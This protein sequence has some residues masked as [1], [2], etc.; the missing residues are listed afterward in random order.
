MARTPIK[1]LIL[2]QL[3][4]QGQE[5]GGASSSGGVKEG[6]SITSTAGINVEAT[7]NSDISGSGAYTDD[8]PKKRTAAEAGCVPTVGRGKKKITPM[9]VA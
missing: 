6:A 2:S 9:A 5:D 3:F 7:V 4:G 8:G 1:S